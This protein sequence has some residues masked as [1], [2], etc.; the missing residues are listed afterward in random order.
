MMKTHSTLSLTQRKRVERGGESITPNTFQVARKHTIH[1]L[2]G[3]HE[4]TFQK[5]KH[6]YQHAVPHEA[7]TR[8]TK[9][10]VSKNGTNPKTDEKIQ[11]ALL[12][13]NRVNHAFLSQGPGVYPTLLSK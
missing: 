7:T 2:H 4:A 12:A 8:I 13:I 6:R 1:E 3:T 5:H 10:Q 11:E 9:V